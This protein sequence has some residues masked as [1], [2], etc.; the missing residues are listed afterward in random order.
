MCISGIPLCV[1]CA[2]WKCN[3]SGW[4][5]AFRR[6]SGCPSSCALWGWKP[7]NIL[8]GW[9][10]HNIYVH[11][12]ECSNDFYCKSYYTTQLL[13]RP[14]TNQTNV[15]FDSITPIY[16]QAI[17]LYQPAL[18]HQVFIHSHRRPPEICSDPIIHAAFHTPVRQRTLLATLQHTNTHPH[19]HRTLFEPGAVS[20]II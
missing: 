6:T 2:G 15:Y 11:I 17:T 16:R 1:V 20:W 3:A 8:R 4:A 9:W 7:D 12:C 14:V 18:L 13:S 5:F 10:L 19:T